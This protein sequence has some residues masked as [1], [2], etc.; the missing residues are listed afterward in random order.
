MSLRILALLAVV[1]VAGPPAEGQGGA[2]PAQAVPES[3]LTQDEIRRFIRQLGSPL[4]ARR[5]EAR[6]I[7][8]A[9]GRAAVKELF[10]AQ[11]DD[12]EQIASRAREVLGKIPLPGFTLQTAGGKPVAHCRVEFF[13][14]VPNST[15]LVD[16]PFA[17]G[18]TDSGGG[19]ALPVLPPQAAV[20][21]RVT[22]PRW[23]TT[24]T[25]FT[26]TETARFAQGQNPG[27]R[28]VWL[29]VVAAN[30]SYRER[31]VEGVVQ[32]ESG[33]P[34]PGAEVHCR[35]VRTN[36]GNGISALTPLS[37]VISSRTG[38]FR[39]YLPSQ[40]P[41]MDPFQR[42]RQL[43]QN[44]L[45]ENCEYQ[46]VVRVPGDLTYCPVE[47]WQNNTKPAVITLLRTHRPRTFRFESP[48]GG[49]VTAKND[50]AQIT[51]RHQPLKPATGDQW[52][53]IDQ[54]IV[55]EGGPVHRG[56]YWASYESEAG[57]RVSWRHLI[58]TDDGPDELTFRLP[59][60]VVYRGR[61]VDPVTGQPL[62]GVFVGGYQSV[63]QKT[64]ASIT[65]EEWSAAEKL[66]QTPA[67]DDKA[68]KPFLQVNGFSQIVRTAQDGRYEL[69][70]PRETRF[71]GIAAFARSRLPIRDRVFPGR[72]EIAD[73]PLFPAAKI[74]V[75]PVPPSAAE[76]Q[77]GMGSFGGSP[78][79]SGVTLFWSFPK[80]A[81]PPW[82]GTF[83]KLTSERVH[84]TVGRPYQAIPVNRESLRF[85]PAELPV[86]LAFEA[87]DDARWLPR[88]PRPLKLAKGEIYD[89]GALTFAP[90]L[91]IQ[92]QVVDASGKPVAG[93]SIRKLLNRGEEQVWTIGRETD[94]NGLARFHGPRNSQVSF[95][96]APD[97][98]APGD[99]RKHFAVRVNTTTK[100]FPPREPVRIRLT[101]EQIQTLFNR[102]E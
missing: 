86:Q 58:V 24:V 82:T 10:L 72:N 50:R 87:G 75:R 68:L 46:L 90:A 95:Q 79:P 2:G 93:V 21:L 65:D 91:R 35:Y 52:V 45:P 11:S 7:L 8:L 88:N 99:S 74:R 78:V 98:L 48:R 100:E 15:Q 69:R 67:I 12:N 64:F 73:L 4:E 81:Q 80:A 44:P 31:A 70:Q 27:F 89:L 16:V 22:H 1:A 77:L 63:T 76:V 17:R 41:A 56:R 54:R 55:L 18:S 29:P 14:L 3:L 9:T 49:Y 57:S 28:T 43:R 40:E 66:P 36:G 19:V 38:R 51:L 71:Y 47:L 102:P 32:D 26:K 42:M 6:R 53:E 62:A 13:D 61:V 34:I 101:A 20:A 97:I 96:V 33:R 5:I 92:V 84:C 39:L 94:A 85:V 30:S 37:C 60:P 23:G 59:P 83:R 25:R